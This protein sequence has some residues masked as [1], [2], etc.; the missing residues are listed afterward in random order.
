[1]SHISHIVGGHF[2][3]NMTCMTDMTYM[4]DMTHMTYMPHLTQKTYSLNL[5][6]FRFKKQLF[7]T[8]NRSKSQEA[9]DLLW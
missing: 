9:N 3:T 2:L 7:L 5:S 1:M 4:T 6:F 8:K